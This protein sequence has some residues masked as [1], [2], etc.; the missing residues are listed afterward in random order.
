MKNQPLDDTLEDVI[1][2]YRENVKM[3]DM[4]KAAPGRFTWELE[5][6]E[7]NL[8][9]QYN[10][11]ERR[12]PEAHHLSIASLKDSFIVTDITPPFV[13]RAR[14][15]IINLHMRLWALINTKTHS[16]NS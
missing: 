3:R 16:T 7:E 11:M 2:I 9:S 13:D 10:L 6:I 5:D 12:I 14:A 4:K 15:G 1:D 8:I